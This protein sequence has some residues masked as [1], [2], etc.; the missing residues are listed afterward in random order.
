[1]LKI[2]HVLAF[3]RYAPRNSTIKVIIHKSIDMVL[4]WLRYL[5]QYEILKKSMLRGHM[6]K[7]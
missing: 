4:K 1:M 2:G 5:V 7:K 6:I 3:A